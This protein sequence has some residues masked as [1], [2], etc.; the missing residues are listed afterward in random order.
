MPEYHISHQKGSESWGILFLQIYGNPDR[1]K[2]SLHYKILG[3]QYNTSDVA[4]VQSKFSADHPFGTALISIFSTW[5]QQK[6]M[7]EA[8][9]RL[10]VDA[11]I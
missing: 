3:C 1:I 8:K 11:E 2:Y 10:N 5:E 7:L 9:E 6:T 4:I